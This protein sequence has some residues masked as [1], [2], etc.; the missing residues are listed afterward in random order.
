MRTPLQDGSSWTRGGFLAAVGVLFALQ[1]G[2][3]LLFGDRSLPSPPRVVPTARFRA[4]VTP[5]DGPELLRLFFVSDPAVF[6]LPNPR[7]F[8][9]RA[10]L[11]QRP[12]AFQSEVQ[13]EPPCWLTLDTTG[14]GTNFPA[15][16][17]EYAAIRP[18]LVQQQA[19]HVEPLPVFLAP[20]TVPTQSVFRLEGQ[21]EGSLLGQPLQLHAWPS[22]QLLSNS[23]VQIAVDP[24]GAVLAARLECRSGSVDADAEAVA[25]ARALRFT[26]RLAARTRWGEAVFQWQTTEPPAADPP[27]KT[28]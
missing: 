20:E 3:I 24:A 5:V 28:P 27:G 15:L 13:L 12:P 25:L 16:P 9:G 6:P 17:M 1:A 26:P 8:S 22:P 4:L 2:L 18:E 11:N 7:G 10:W 14:L 23:V 19:L 21:M